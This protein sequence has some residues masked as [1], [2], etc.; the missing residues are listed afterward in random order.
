MAQFHLYSAVQM[1]LSKKYILSHVLIYVA[2]ITGL[3]VCLLWNFIAV[4]VAWIDGEGCLEI[5]HSILYSYSE[6][7]CFVDV[8][9]HTGLVQD[10]QSGFLLLSTSYQGFQEVMSSGIGLCIVL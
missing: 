1:Y 8:Y 7:F 10:Q 2:L 4:T 5:F 6:I 3:I 9:L